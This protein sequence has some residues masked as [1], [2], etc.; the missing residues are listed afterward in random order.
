MEPPA[1]RARTGP[2]A[3][4][5]GDDEEAND[6]ELTLSAV[7]FDAR[8]HPMYQLD[9]RR[10]RS[11]FKLKSTFED[12][13]VKY[14][15]DFD[16]VG[17][18]IDLRTGQVVIDNGH[19]QSLEDK[20]QDKSEDEEDDQDQTLQQDRNRAKRNKSDETLQ[21]RRASHGPPFQSPNLATG[22]F[23]PAWQ[24]PDL[25]SSVPSPG[26][27]S[28]A[29]FSN[30][31]YQPLVGATGPATGYG[32]F[33]ALG[34]P[35]RRF[36]A[37]K[38]VGPKPFRLSDANEEDQCTESEEKEEEEVD[39]VDE[40]DDLQSM[41]AH[42]EN[43]IPRPHKKRLSELVAVSFTGLEVAPKDQRQ[44]SALDHPQGTSPSRRRRGRPK[45]QPKGQPIVE[46]KNIPRSNRT[47]D[48]DPDGINPSTQKL[49]RSSTDIVTQE[50]VATHGR[51]QA[52]TPITDDSSDSQSRRSARM[53]K[54]PQRYDQMSWFVGGQGKQTTTRVMTPPPDPQSHLLGRK[55]LPGGTMTQTLPFRCTLDTE[56]SNATED[57]DARHL[58][59]DPVATDISK[60]VTLSG[61]PHA[62]DKIVRN[63]EH[64]NSKLYQNVFEDTQALSSSMPD[65]NLGVTN[66]S[67]NIAMESLATPN[68]PSGSHTHIIS[69]PPLIDSASTSTQDLPDDQQER[70]SA[71]KGAGVTTDKES[72]SGASQREAP[73]QNTHEQEIL[74]DCDDADESIELGEPITPHTANGPEEIESLERS[75]G[76]SRTPSPE[77]NIR[78]V[79]D[80]DEFSLSETRSLGVT[81]HTKNLRS[82]TRPISAEGSPPHPA[83]VDKARCHPIESP[84]KQS[85]TTSPIQDT[86]YSPS[87]R[88]PQPPSPKS[89]SKPHPRTPKKTRVFS[90]LVADASDLEDELSI[91]SSSVARTPTS[92]ASLRA[93][94]IRGVSQTPSA[95]RASPTPRHLHLGRKPSL[96]RLPATD[97]GA[98]RYGLK[99]RQPTTSGLAQS[100]PLARSVLLR[101]PQKKVDSGGSRAGSPTDST[102][103]TPRGT[104]MRC[105]EDGFVCDRDFC[106]TCCE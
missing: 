91:L 50:P 26:F 93:S 38:D 62:T 6:D 56:R 68:A 67:T 74:Q 44:E 22:T 17:D 60:P 15:K 8:Q 49:H 103:R 39:H 97:G 20:D 70:V 12:I 27:G 5:D 82:R 94:F 35:Y 90:S 28:A 32:F 2:A 88:Q 76:G 29:P 45:R 69:T 42:H 92:N 36:V 101:T 78:R 66:E 11:A 84:K 73:V 83:P 85:A 23:D 89:Q 47:L 43:P 87:Q 34:Q 14:G 33:S 81:R 10:A 102:M 100:S 30:N 46:V 63:T 59:D 37:A 95:A 9:K 3:W 55:S 75:V 7:Q 52:Q 53:R 24:T 77:R 99:R 57:T 98:V 71:E 31:G 79:D 105:G 72:L 1:K 104:T 25:E 64:S 54:Q 61:S 13:F 18:E 19:L 80:T 40:E 86:P 51:W 41:S 4:D 106:F 48:I 16:G 58:V 21:R 65:P 96:P